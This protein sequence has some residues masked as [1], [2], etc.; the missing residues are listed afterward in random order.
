[1]SVDYCFEERKKPWILVSRRR[2][3]NSRW[4]LG[5]NKA[6]LFSKWDVFVSPPMLLFLFSSYTICNNVLWFWSILSVTIYRVSI[7]GVE[8]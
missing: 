7:V 8:N 2:R 5:M 6:F 3:P 4:S 1:M